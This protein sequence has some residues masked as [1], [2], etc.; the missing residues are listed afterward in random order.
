VLDAGENK[1]LLCCSRQAGKSTV[2][3]LLACRVAVLEPNSLVLCV[4]PSMRQSNELFRKVKDFY[5]G[6]SALPS[7]P[8]VKLESALRLELVN[9]SRVVSLPGSERTTRGYSKASLIVLDE[10]ARIAD[11]LITSLQPMQAT[12][13]AGRRRF[14]A[15]STPYGG[16]AGTSSAGRAPIP[17]G[18]R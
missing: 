7:R 3:E 13:L 18:S 9:G 1:L 10:A 15:M 14:I 6:L 12:S 4:S 5:G 2:A 8:E 17:D 16:E 11:E